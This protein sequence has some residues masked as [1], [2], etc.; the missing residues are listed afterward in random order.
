MK[1]KDIQKPSHEQ[2]IDSDQ[3]LHPTPEVPEIKVVE[4]RKEESEDPAEVCIEIVRPTR[5]AC[6]S[7]RLS[8]HEVCILLSWSDLLQEH[9]L[10]G[11]L[12]ESIV[13]HSKLQFVLFQ[14]TEG[15]RELRN[16]SNG[17]FKVHHRRMFINNHSSS[18]LISNKLSVNEERQS[19]KESQWQ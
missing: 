10:Q 8:C 17:D 6:L 12:G 13:Y 18:E 15:N 11:A 2:L 14:D 19:Q 1:L 7:L 3:I 4:S 5:D 16:R 9:L